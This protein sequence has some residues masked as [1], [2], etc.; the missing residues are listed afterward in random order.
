MGSL[1]EKVNSPADIRK[2]D[3]DQLEVLC[4]EIR[5]YMVECCSHNPGHLGASLGAVELAVAVHYVF[6]TPYDKL[7]WD[8]GHQAY[9][10]KI[11]TGRKEAFR[12]NRSKDGLSGFPK[13]SESPYDSFGVGH[14]STS[15][16]ASLGMAVAARLNGQ[17]KK[18]IAVIGDGA[19]TG[20]LAY[21]GLNQAGFL[22]ND[23][24]VILND[25]GI[26]IDPTSGALHNHL[27]RIS[28]SKTYNSIKT[29]IWN[30]ISAPT[31]KLFRKISFSTKAALMNSTKGSMFESLGMRYFGAINGNDIRMLVET[32]TSLKD[33]EGPKLLHVITRKGKGYAPA[34]KNQEIWHAP[35]KFDPETGARTPGCADI[36]RYQDVFGETL[37]ELAGHNDRIIAVTPAMASGSGLLP[38]MDKYPDRCFDVGIAEQHAVTFSAGLATEGWLPFCCIYST[39][40]QRGY[41]GIIHDVALQGLKVI[42]CLDRAGLVGEDGPTHHGAFDL[43]FCRPIPGIAI[44]SPLN[45]TELRNLLYSVQDDTYPATVIRY[46]RGLAQG[47]QWRNLPFSKIELGRANLLHEGSGI[48]ILSI[49]PVGNLVCEAVREASKKNVEVM[50][51]DM[52]FLK[53]IDTE[54]IDRTA[55]KCR[56]IIS[57]EDGTTIGGLHGAVAE[58]LS[59][60]GYTGEIISLGIPDTFIEQG[61]VNELRSECSFGKDDIF[62]QIIEKSLE[63]KK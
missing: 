1:L 3:L 12:R 45:E 31:Q 25:N 17:K 41:D 21:E 55:E 50:H 59:G 9:A 7:I 10:H 48:G 46:P 2:M 16:S 47:V 11:I 27:L 15:V 32:L 35:G 63:I 43:A 44:V 13:R 22:K 62:R 56:I 8:V 18:V 34:E 61:T 23:I 5:E 6:D 49:G 42:F 38:M 4:S 40:M 54:A 14:A 29:K 57:V 39:F 24:L 51:Y 33:I 20:G 30:R 52:R 53:P 28:T 26:S 19:M 58:Y 60:K 37:V 36:S